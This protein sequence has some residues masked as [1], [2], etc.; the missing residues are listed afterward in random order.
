MLLHDWVHCSGETILHWVAWQSP[1]VLRLLQ[2]PHKLPS[3]RLRQAFHTIF[4][5]M[6]DGRICLLRTW[7]PS[8][9]ACLVHGPLEMWTMMDCLQ[10]FMSWPNNCHV[11]F[12]WS[13]EDVPGVG[14]S[15]G[16][17]SCKSSAGNK[18]ALRTAYWI[19]PRWRMNAMMVQGL[20]S[21]KLRAHEFFVSGSRKKCKTWRSNVIEFNKGYP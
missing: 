16:Y 14:T 21:G 19:R 15:S 20:G 8:G 1:N 6:V 13:A 17:W 3:N 10:M 11:S 5:P 2:I 7:G 12:K 9:I 4:F 18:N